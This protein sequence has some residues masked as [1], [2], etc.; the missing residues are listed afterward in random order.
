MG[1]TFPVINSSVFPSGC[2]RIFF[3]AP[4][5][6]VQ[7]LVFYSGM[8]TLE[9]SKAPIFLTRFPQRTELYR[10]LTLNTCAYTTEIFAGRFARCRTVRMKRRTGP[11]AFSSFKMY[12]CIFCRRRTSPCLP[13]ATKCNVLHSTALAFAATVPDLLKSPA[14]LT[15]R[16]TNAF[17]VRR[18]VFSFRMS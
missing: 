10:A 7:L 11:M 5:A 16:L 3:A 6:C 17:C 1:R 9:M 4:P 13:T 15:Q 8:Y 18:V 14:I 12:R 2:S